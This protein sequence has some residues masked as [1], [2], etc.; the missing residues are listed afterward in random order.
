MAAIEL[1][2]DKK[3]K[4]PLD[5]DS[6]GSIFNAICDNGVLV[7]ASGNNFI[8]SPSLIIKSEEI[9][10]I[11]NAIDSGFK[12]FLNW[13]WITNDNKKHPVYYGRSTKMGLSFMLWPSTYS[14]TQHRLFIE[15]WH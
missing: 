9:D 4:K 10:R 7:R 1:V 13:Q 8:L 2:S 5:K 11:I 14:H 15:N 6:V 3:S 12:N